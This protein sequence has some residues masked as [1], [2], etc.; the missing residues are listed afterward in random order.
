M[1]LSGQWTES[2]LNALA[3][4]VLDG[5]GAVAIL[6]IATRYLWHSHPGL[7]DRRRPGSGRSSR[8]GFPESRRS[9]VSPGTG[10]RAEQL[11]AR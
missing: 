6:N 5:D 11:A 2:M 9:T 3:E 8:G 1:P 10:R 7:P 4:L